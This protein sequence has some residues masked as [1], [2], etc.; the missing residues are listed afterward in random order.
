M[1]FFKDI[2]RS[3]ST[4]ERAVFFIALICLAGSLLTLTI[5]NLA[6]ATVTIPAQGGEYTEGFVGQPAYINPVL[7]STDIDRSLVRILFSNIPSLASKMEL[8]GDNRTWDIRLKENLFWNDREKLTSDDVLFTIQKIQDPESRSPLALS[9]QGISARRVSELELIIELPSPYA[10][11]DQTL[12]NLYILPKH[13]FADI[14]LSNWRLSDYNLKAVG[15]GSYQFLSYQQQSDG[16]IDRY[17]LRAEKTSSENPRISLITLQFF[18]NFN[19]ALQAFNLGYIDGLG[20]VEPSALASIQRPY[21]L[22]AFSTP[23]Y[24]AVFLNGMRNETFKDP[25]VR[26]VLSRA[27][28]RKTLIAQALKGYG[29]PREGPLIPEEISTSLR[30]TSSTANL[31]NA[32]EADGWL[33]STSTDARVK[34]Q[35]KSSSTLTATLLVPQVPFLVTTAEMLRDAWQQLGFMIT[36]QPASPNDILSSAIYNRDYEMLLFGN[37]LNPP[38]DLFPFWHSSQRFYPGFNIGLYNNKK[39]DVLAESIR[40]EMDPTKRGVKL[41]TLS[42]LITSDA[43]AIF[44]YSPQYLFISEKNLGGVDPR[45]IANPAERFLN[46]ASWYVKTARVLK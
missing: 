22:Y 24:Y 43:P 44:L 40:E 4:R 13:L 32:L 36:L 34:V 31:I 8:G 14:P 37:V 1:K 23:S 33:T 3:F 29:T 6:R 16:F 25:I 30:S 15:S 5:L 18:R 11:F 17:E 27:I 26:T 42:S 41:Q 35:G 38:E 46:V 39:A 45:P 20:G 28:D 12:D 9:W 2:L 7:A 19:E 21:T 10:F